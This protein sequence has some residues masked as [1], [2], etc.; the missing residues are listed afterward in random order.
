MLSDLEIAFRNQEDFV[1]NASH[2]LRTPLSV[3]ISETDYFLSRERTR[4]EYVE[5]ISELIRDLKKINTL[6]NSLL[7]L[8]QVTKDKNIGFL[9]VRIDEIVFDA[10]HQV[11]SKYPDHKIIPKIQYPE[12][13]NDLIIIGNE[14]L[15][16]IA[17]KNLIDNVSFQM[18]MYWWN[19]T[20]KEIILVLLLLT[21]GSVFRI[22][23]CRTSTS[24]SQGDQTLSSSGDS[25]S[26]S[27]WSQR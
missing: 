26:A 21:T 2:E 13:E 3:M 19:L 20:S 24:P 16:T 4:E 11:K 6:L 23:N 18:K 25:V 5:H 14:G 1:S 15:L 17:F 9:P 7:E 8:A 22:L 10:I 12:N 27:Q